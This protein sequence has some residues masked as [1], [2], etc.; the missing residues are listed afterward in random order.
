MSAAEDQTAELELLNNV[1]FV[2]NDTNKFKL[3]L[4]IGEDAY[5]SLKLAKSLQAL[6]GT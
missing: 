1:E 6:S 2:V 3:K 5:K 4:G